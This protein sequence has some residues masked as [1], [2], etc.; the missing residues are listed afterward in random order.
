MAALGWSVLRITVGVLAGTAALAA[1][2]GLLA[3]VSGSM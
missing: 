3:I 1:I 2:A